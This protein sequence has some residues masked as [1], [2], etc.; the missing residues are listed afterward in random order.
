[1][2]VAILCV[3]YSPRL[4]KTGGPLYFTFSTPM[5]SS[6]II[7]P[8]PLHLGVHN[9][10]SLRVS[11]SLSIHFCDNSFDCHTPLVP[12]ILIIRTPQIGVNK[13]W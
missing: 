12:H 6:K 10:D 7:K 13:S 5:R 2:Y 4:V 3:V 8:K 11:H 1:M 9:Y